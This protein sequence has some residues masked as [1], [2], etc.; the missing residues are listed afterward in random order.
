MKHL[1]VFA[2]VFAAMSL[3]A[4]IQKAAVI[5]GVLNVR[6]RPSSKS[7]TILQL[8]RGDEVTVVEKGAEWTAIRPP[9]KSSLYVSSPLIADG[10]MKSNGNLRAGSGVNFQ[11]LCILPAGT[12][13][14]VI[15]DKN[16]WSR[17]AV[18]AVDV[19][20]YVATQYLKFAPAPVTAPADNKK[21]ETPAVQKPVQKGDVVSFNAASLKRI[22]KDYVK[23]TEKNVK[24]SGI[25]S[26][27]SSKEHGK[28][29]VISVDERYYHLAG[30]IP[31]N[32]DRSKAVEVK[33]ISRMVRTWSVP[34]IEIEKITQK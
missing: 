8:K 21:T 13:V 3:C 22:S 34:I 33:G 2:T 17:I 10:K 32:I 24:V 28:T 19:R 11:S 7:D 5:A 31:A 26:E 12:P 25:I 18:P 6:V 27:I 29:F 20:C 9:A 1:F 23:G 16:S 14:S 30:V 4:E 15:E